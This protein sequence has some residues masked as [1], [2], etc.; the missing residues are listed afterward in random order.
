MGIE[1]E[2]PEENNQAKRIAYITG[3]IVSEMYLACMKLMK[4]VDHTE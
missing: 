1:G 3:G 4:G 2:T